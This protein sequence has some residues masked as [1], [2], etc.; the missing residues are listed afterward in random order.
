MERRLQPPRRQMA[1]APLPPPRPTLRVQP[2]A[3]TQAQ[4]GVSVHLSGMQQDGDT[5][6]ATEFPSGR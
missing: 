5:L 4:P 1:Q 3:G 6:T 2:P